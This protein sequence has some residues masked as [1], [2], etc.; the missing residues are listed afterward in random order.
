MKK[1]KRKHKKVSSEAK[2]N[3]IIALI[4][5]LIAILTLIESLLK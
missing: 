1:H 5:L 2:I 3:L 4:N